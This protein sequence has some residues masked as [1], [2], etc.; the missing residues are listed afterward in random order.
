MIYVLKSIQEASEFLGVNAMTLRR[1]I[2]EGK[3]SVVRLG[4]RVLI[5]EEVLE[6]LIRRNEQPATL[7]L[8]TTERGE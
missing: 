4:R 3:I 8:S 1:W 5:R 7:P 2:G 6:D